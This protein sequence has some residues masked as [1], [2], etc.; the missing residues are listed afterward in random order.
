M[1]W[2]EWKFEYALYLRPGD[3]ISLEGAKW[4][5]LR[6]EFFPKDGIYSLVLKAGPHE[7]CIYLTQ[8]HQVV[9][10]HPSSSMAF[11]AALL[12]LLGIAGIPVAWIFFP[13]FWFLSLLPAFASS[14]CLYNY[15]QHGEIRL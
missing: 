5:V 7:A 9:K 2:G 3:W 15:L 12:V 14:I 10:L 11:V 6:K 8:M 1:I 13:N 4:K